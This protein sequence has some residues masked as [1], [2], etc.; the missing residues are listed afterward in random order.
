MTQIVSQSGNLEGMEFLN[1]PA[2]ICEYSE[3]HLPTINWDNV[4]ATKWKKTALRGP[5]PSKELKNYGLEF[6]STSPL[7]DIVLEFD[8]QLKDGT[9]RAATLSLRP[10]DDGTLK[11]IPSRQVSG[12]S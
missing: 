1:L 10:A 9:S 8:I 12:R 3:T 11:I 7:I 6:A 4:V 2:V 5:G